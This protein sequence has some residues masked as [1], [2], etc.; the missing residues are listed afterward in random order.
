M[1][2]RGGNAANMSNILENEKCAC[3][4]GNLDRFI[5]PIILMI[6]KEEP[7]TGYR[8]LK[9][10]EQFS[11][12]GDSRPD[13]TG[14]YRYLRLMEER[15]LLEQFEEREGENKYK[16]KYRI[17]ENGKECL[18]NWKGTLTAYAKAIEELVERMN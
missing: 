15:E 1:E 13:A 16:K 14:V 17:T 10:M 6:L 11:M 8:I 7:S 2:I 12:F 3:R 9:Q 5:Q 18:E 4:G